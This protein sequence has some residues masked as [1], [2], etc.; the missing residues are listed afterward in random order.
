[1]WCPCPKDFKNPWILTH[2][3][4]LFANDA[5]NNYFPI[6]HELQKWEYMRN[7]TV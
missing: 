2:T 7:A 6:P 5:K 4:I 3:P 1:M